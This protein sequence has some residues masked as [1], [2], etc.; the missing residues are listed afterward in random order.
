MITLDTTRTARYVDLSPP[1]DARYRIG[2]GT[3]WQNDSAGG[4]VISVSRADP[5]DS[6]SR[7]FEAAGLF[8]LLAGAALLFSRTLDA[9]PN[10]DEGVYLAS[11]DAL[12]RGGQ[13]GEDVFASQPP[14]F[15]LLLRLATVLPGGTVEATR[16]LF[17]VVALVGVAAAWSLGRRWRAAS[18]GLPLVLSLWPRPPSPSSRRASQPTCPRSPLHSSPSRCWP[19]RSSDSPC[20]SPPLQG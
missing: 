2:I 20:R 6:V 5:G 4:D 7:R 8:G 17:L 10:Y 11:A 9:G 1:E 12:A 16:A 13:L 15:Y 3:N 18:P 19:R 14:G